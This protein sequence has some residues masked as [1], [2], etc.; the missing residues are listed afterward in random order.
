MDFIS[1][2]ARESRDRLFIPC[3]QPDV[4]GQ[5]THTPITTHITLPNLR[6]FWFEALALTW[7]RLFIGSR[8]LAS[9][10]WKFNSSSNSRFSFHVSRSYEH[11]REPQVRQCRNHVQ[12]Q[13]N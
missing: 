4:E 9:K 13:A 12:G 10:A 7:K 6:F 5:V 1:A 3:S 8:P 2:P 11:N